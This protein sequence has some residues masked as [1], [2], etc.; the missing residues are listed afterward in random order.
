MIYIY[1]VMYYVIYQFPDIYIN[2]TYAYTL[3]YIDK[4]LSYVYDVYDVYVYIYIY[5]M[6][7]HLYGY[8]YWYINILNREFRKIIKSNGWP[9]D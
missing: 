7:Y 8:S 1:M 2:Q 3:F 6:I 4:P 9:S 5:T